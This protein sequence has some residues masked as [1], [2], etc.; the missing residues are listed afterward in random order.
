LR[1]AED[2]TV[3]AVLHSF[4]RVYEFDALGVTAGVKPE[5]DQ[6]CVIVFDNENRGTVIWTGG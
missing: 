4:S 1:V 5:A 3:A 2:G 6:E